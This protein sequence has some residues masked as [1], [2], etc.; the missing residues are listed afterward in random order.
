MIPYYF[1][2]KNEY[3]SLSED[4]CHGSGILPPPSTQCLFTNSVRIRTYKLLVN[5]IDA[6]RMFIFGTSR[7]CENVTSSNSGRYLLVSLLFKANAIA[8]HYFSLRFF[9]CD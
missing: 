4:V 5:T 8:N 9:D 7:N 6:N 1:F 2:C 3:F